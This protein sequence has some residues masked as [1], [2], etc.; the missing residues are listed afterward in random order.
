MGGVPLEHALS[1]NHLNYLKYSTTVLAGR[2]FLL[3]EHGV[4]LPRHKDG[5]IVLS[6]AAIGL[7]RLLR[8]MRPHD[9]GRRLPTEDDAALAYIDQ[10]LKAWPEMDSGKRWAEVPPAATSQV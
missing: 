7:Q 6:Y 5:G 3:A 1:A 4:P 9:S 10:W 2:Y 8:L